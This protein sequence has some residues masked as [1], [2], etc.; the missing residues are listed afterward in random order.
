M[1]L[2]YHKPCSLALNIFYG[3]KKLSC[4]PFLEIYSSIEFT[5]NLKGLHLFMIILA[6]MI[7]KSCKIILSVLYFPRTQK[8]HFQLGWRSGCVT[9]Q[10]NNA[11][12]YT[13]FLNRRTAIQ[14][15]GLG[16]FLNYLHNC[17][18]SC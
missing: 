6:H 18:Q 9:L 10:L 4:V 17:F 11:V 1:S 12:L 13:G 16:K 5:S 3:T 8:L 14:N 2:R 7:R 15:P